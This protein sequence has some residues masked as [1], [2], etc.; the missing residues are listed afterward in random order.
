[1]S[2][3]NPRYLRH[4]ETFPDCRRERTLVVQMGGRH[5]PRCSTLLIASIA[6]AGIP[7]ILSDHPGIHRGRDHWLR[8]S[9]D[10]LVRKVNEDVD[11]EHLDFAPPILN[12]RLA[13]AS[14]NYANIWVVVHANDPSE[15]IERLSLLAGGH[16]DFPTLM[17]ITGSSGL[18]VR[19]YPNPAAAL[20]EFRGLESSGV[21]RTGDYAE[22]SLATAGLLINE[23]MLGGTAAGDDLGVA[24]TIGFYSTKRRRRVDVNRGETLTELV[25]EIAQP[26]APTIAFSKKRLKS[27]GAGTLAQLAAVSISV[28]EGEVAMELYDGDETID[29]HNL[30]R[31]ILLVGHVGEGPKAPVVARELAGLD[32][33][34]NYKGIVRYVKA[35]EDLDPLNVHAL[36]GLPDDDSPRAVA[37]IAAWDAGI[38]YAQ[39]G[40]SATGGQFTIQEPG[41]ACLCCLTSIS[42]DSASPPPA[43]R[44]SRDNSC[45]RAPDSVISSNAVVA[46]LMV[47]ELRRCLAGAKSENLRFH[48][49]GGGGNRLRWMIGDPDCPHRREGGRRSTVPSGRAGLSVS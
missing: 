42:L 13:H 4:G 14:G 36:L 9:H 35:P 46:G 15:A 49:R 22:L 34:G 7:R 30:Q 25:R 37:G 39:A 6:M 10:R 26:A 23:I 27:V 32:C 31:Q 41:R 21:V 44:Q 18:L 5:A 11:F 28:A 47:S 16:F 33:R 48:G 17:T 3:N 38:P 2:T 45:A 24:R 12:R 8:F 20:V 1:M 29:E 43:H 40:T 19:R